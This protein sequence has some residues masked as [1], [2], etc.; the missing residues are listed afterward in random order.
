MMHDAQTRAYVER[1]ITE[2]LIEREIRRILKRYLA[3][4]I[5]RALTAASGADELTANPTP[6][7]PQTSHHRRL[8]AIPSVQQAAETD[9]SELCTH[10][11][12]LRA[13]RCGA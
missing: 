10:Q 5:H 12:I 4:Q 1:R 9:L 6:R 13:L 3:R 2:G 11:S 8:Q 7:Q